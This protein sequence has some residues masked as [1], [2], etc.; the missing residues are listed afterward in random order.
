MVFIWSSGWGPRR[1]RPRRRYGRS[2]YGRGY[3]YGSP[4]GYGHGRGYGRRNDSCLRDLLFLNTGC[5]LANAVGCGM[6]AVLL[7]PVTAGRM[8][9]A[10]TG[11]RGA[12]LA[13]RMVAAVRVYQREIS[14]KRV[15]C[16]RYEP[17]CSAYAVQALERHGA[18]RGSWLTLRRLVRCRPGA[19]G[20]PDPVPGAA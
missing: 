12:R 11:E 9:T 4:P 16:C 13:D 10:G 18:G 6:D 3:G 5:C 2:G 14:P 8:R 15:P 19:A 20:G 7:A 17:T 1:R